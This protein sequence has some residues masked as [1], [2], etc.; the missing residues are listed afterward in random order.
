MFVYN[1]SSR[2]EKFVIVDHRQS[3]VQVTK[4]QLGK[5]NA[6]VSFGVMIS[7]LIIGNMISDLIA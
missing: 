7:N 2:I 1:I 3:A 5:L 4:D 6:L